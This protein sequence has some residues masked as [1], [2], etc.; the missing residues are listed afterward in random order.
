M[1]TGC[2]PSASPASPTASRRLLSCSLSRLVIPA[3][4]GIHRAVFAVS[5]AAWMPAFAGMTKGVA[6]P[7]LELVAA[8]VALGGKIIAV[9][10][11]RRHLERHPLDYG[12]TFRRQRRRLFR[13]VGEQADLG[14]RQ[15]LEHPRRRREIA[16]VVGEAQSQ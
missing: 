13:I 6:E 3:K 10:L 2:A 14:L 16:L 8:A 12:D 5:A 1:A 11:A 15:P 9:M 7:A 4:A